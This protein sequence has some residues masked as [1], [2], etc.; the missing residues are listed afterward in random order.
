MSCTRFVAPPVAAYMAAS[1]ALG[2][3]SAVDGGAAPRAGEVGSASLPIIG[4][5]FDP[6][7][8]AV[9]QVLVSRGL[10][11]GTLVAPRVVMTAAH[12]VSEA[13]EDGDTESGSVRFGNGQDPWIAELGIVDMA[14]HR[15]YAPPAFLQWDIAAVRLAEDAPA[16]IAPIEPN[17]DPLEAPRDIGLSARTIGFGVDDGAGQ[18]GAGLKR[19]VDLTVDEITFYHVGMGTTTQNT[20]QGDSGGPTLVTYGGVERVVGVTSFGS[21]RCRARSYQ[22]RVDSLQ[23]WL[24]P[25]IDSWSGPCQLDGE[26]VTEGC[27]SIDPD[28]DPCGFDGECADD[29]AAID[30]DCPIG[31]RAGDLCED[32][33]DCETRLC[34]EAPD[35]PRIGYCSATCDPARPLDTCPPPFSTCVERDGEPVCVYTGPTPSAQGAPCE[36]D[37]DCRSGVCDTGNEICVE[38]CGGDLPDCAEP[39]SCQDVEGTRACTLG[40]EEDGCSVSGSGRS[41]GTGFVALLSAVF[42]GLAWRRR[43]GP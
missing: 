25:V 39:Y 18:S 30:L 40:G 27:R 43:S 8:D 3:C 33:V 5:S 2:A 21:D 4:G 19:E 41:S 1:L 20:C 38:E 13:I 37:E 36:E 16:E 17:L 29:C 7:D 23:D 15:L 26:C 12:C 6:G 34:L 31:V 11:T 24:L 32:H 14:M 22:T 42:L 9:V 10:C 35:D 28:C